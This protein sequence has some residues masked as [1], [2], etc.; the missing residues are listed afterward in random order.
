MDPWNLPMNLALL[1]NTFVRPPAP[2][3][4]CINMLLT[5]LW[6]STIDPSSHHFWGCRSV[7]VKWPPPPW[8]LR[9]RHY[10]HRTESSRHL[11]SPLLHTTITFSQSIYVCVH[12]LFYVCTCTLFYTFPPPFRQNWSNNGFC[13][14]TQLVPGMENASPMI[15][16]SQ[17]N[18]S[19]LLNPTTVNTGV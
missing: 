10:W 3:T 2:G 5:N 6:H 8:T 14:M 13:I 1:P 11:M 18:V 7:L 17:F 12:V 19:W 9:H 15:F 4:T 16:E